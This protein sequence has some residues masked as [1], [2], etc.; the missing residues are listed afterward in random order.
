MG[1][2]EKDKQ[3]T[4]KQHYIPQ[5]ILKHFKFEGKSIFLCRVPEKSVFLSAISDA[6]EEKYFYEHPLLPENTIE[7]ALRVFDTEYI[8][9]LDCLIDKIEKNEI[10]LYEIYSEMS[11]MFQNVLKMYY[12]SGALHYEFSYLATENEAKMVGLNRFLQVVG[13]SGYLSNLSDTLKKGYDFCLIESENKEFIISDQYISTAAL[14]YKSQFANASNRT[15]GLRD[16]MILIPL[17]SQFYFCLFNG[18]HKPD[19]IKAK[20]HVRL[21]EDQVFSVNSIIF[22]NAFN[23]CAGR[24][25]AILKELCDIKQFE[26]DARSV[27][28]GDENGNLK[29]YCTTKKE[30]FFYEED[31]DIA[32]NVIHYYMT[33][34]NA[35][36]NSNKSHI[37]NIIC[38]CG[39][40]KKYKEC[41]LEKHRIAY[42]AIQAT[43][44]KNQP[45]YKIS[46]CISEMPINEMW[47]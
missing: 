46:G 9:T 17:S 15:I 22:R 11:K 20:E 18:R 4:I 41:C 8:N 2:K 32:S 14:A 13:T 29:F 37:R 43:Q 47:T 25:E 12:R 23:R 33:Y 10:S 24:S 35:L 34:R 40:G 21:S 42:E 44:R 19:Y 26:T 5:G 36:V 1:N 28:S 16:T 31:E 27:F 39:S 45:D 30:I 7:N 38:P 6:M 3:I